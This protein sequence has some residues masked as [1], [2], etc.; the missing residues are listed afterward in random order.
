MARYNG[1]ICE[2]HPAL[3][4][5]RLKGNHACVG[6]HKERRNEWLKSDAGQR[7]R[8]RTNERKKEAIIIKN[9]AAR[10]AQIKEAHARMREVHGILTDEGKGK[11][12]KT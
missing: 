9:A 6:C 11:L 10:E 7:Y 12:Y 1:K 8:E 2:K 4:G 3:A 5:L